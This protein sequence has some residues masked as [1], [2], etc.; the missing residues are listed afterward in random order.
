MTLTWTTSNAP[1]E[2]Y[3]AWSDRTFTVENGQS[4]LQVLLNAGVLIQ[5]GCLTGVCG[6][7]VI[8]YVEG[9]VIHK[10]SCLNEHERQHSSC[11]CVSR[12]R[13]RIVLAL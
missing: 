9:D 10:D 4:T 6:E 8:E 5:A 13:S 12:A 7:C 11:P 1:F 3:L 2:I